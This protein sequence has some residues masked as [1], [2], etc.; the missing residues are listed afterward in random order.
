MHPRGTDLRARPPRP[1]APLAV[2]ALAALLVGGPGTARAGDGSG[3]RNGGTGMAAEARPPIPGAPG[4]GIR[5]K[6][7][8]GSWGNASPVSFGGMVCITEEPATLACYDGDSGA[9]RWSAASSFVDTVEGEARAATVEQ[10]AGLA[11]DE[12]RIGEIRVALGRVQRELR[13]PDA[14]GELQREAQRLIGELDALEARLAPWS[15]RRHAEDKGTIGYASATPLVVGDAIYA[16]FGDGVLASFDS[17]GRRRWSVWLGPQIEPMIGNHTGT[18]ASLLM[19]EGVLVAPFG[20]TAG[21]DPSSGELL[22]RGVPYPHFG[23]PAVARVGE[24]AVLVTPGG[25]LLDPADGTVLGP[26]LG[27]IDFVGPVAEGAKV[28][29]I[30]VDSTQ[31]DIEATR[32]RAFEL[33]WGPDGRLEAARLW[34]RELHHRPTWATPLLAGDRL[35]VQYVSGELDVLS[36]VTGEGLARIDTGISAFNGSPSP[37]AGGGTVIVGYE[38]GE[39]RAYSLADKPRQLGELKLEPHFATPLLLGDRIY[40]RGLEHLYCVE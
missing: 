7:P 31:P 26:G 30:G 12:A 13:Q 21:L 38:R 22:W 2:L 4:V 27:Q 37:T 5:W 15:D 33:R 9:L 8:T 14:G 24:R 39:L 17:S 6:V 19:V 3:W 28:W 20:R 36:A 1:G 40:V 35:I 16:L 11:R 23:T 18:A 25:E 32:A 34:E 10:F 29:A